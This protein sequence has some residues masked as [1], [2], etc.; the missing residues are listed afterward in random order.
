MPAPLQC[1]RVRSSREAAEAEC[2]RLTLRTLSAADMQP[3]SAA[4]QQTRSTPPQ[5]YRD[6]LETMFSFLTFEELNTTL[7]VCDDWL[8]AVRSMGGLPAD[9]LVRD[10]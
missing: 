4:A 9:C 2:E 5:L 1:Q 8:A 7:R 3:S 10:G 6:V